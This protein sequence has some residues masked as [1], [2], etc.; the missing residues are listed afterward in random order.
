LTKDIASHPAI[1]IYARLFRTLPAWLF[2][3]N[4]RVLAINGFNSTRKKLNKTY[5]WEIFV[6]KPLEA[7]VTD[8][9]AINLFVIPTLTAVHDFAAQ[10]IS[11]LN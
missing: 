1:S 3:H 9:G 7:P 4:L 11:L 5:E 2:G 6:S 8:E 10:E